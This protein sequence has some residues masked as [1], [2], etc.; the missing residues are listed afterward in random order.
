MLE[1]VT[2]LFGEFQD[3]WM[4]LHIS[5]ELPKKKKKYIYIYIKD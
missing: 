3:Q 5:I 2:F 1:Y 4:K